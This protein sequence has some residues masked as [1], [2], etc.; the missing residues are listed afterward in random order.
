MTPGSLISLGYC[1]IPNTHFSYRIKYVS[2]HG[3]VGIHLLVAETS[4]NLPEVP[5]PKPPLPPPVTRLSPRSPSS[6][7]AGR[8]SNEFSN[9]GCQGG[10]GDSFTLDDELKMQL[11]D[12]VFVL[13]IAVLSTL[14]LLVTCCR[15]ALCASCCCG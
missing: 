12:V 9:I 1:L 14:S 13:R 3:A 7:M 6:G 8:C 5:P 4:S 15:W 2:L 10:P 11:V